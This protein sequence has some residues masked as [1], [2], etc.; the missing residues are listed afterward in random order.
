M[1][2]VFFHKNTLV[3]FYNLIITHYMEE[4]F[5][6]IYFYEYFYNNLVLYKLH[7]FN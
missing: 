2:V 7:S 6:I 4:Y 5:S 1:G 3:Q